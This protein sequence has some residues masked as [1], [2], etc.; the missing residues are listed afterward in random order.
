[1]GIG[2]KNFNH[3]PDTGAAVCAAGTSGAGARVDAVRHISMS[4]VSGPLEHV[5]PHEHDTTRSAAMSKR[6]I[7]R[8]HLMSMWL[9]R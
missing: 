1:M 6:C 8:R 3:L 4:G 7:P 9:T 2:I 5:A